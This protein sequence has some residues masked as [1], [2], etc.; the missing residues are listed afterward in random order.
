M[1]CP[2]VFFF[3]KTKSETILSTGFLFW[4]WQII[5]IT[6][7]FIWSC[8]FYC[9]DNREIV[10]C[11]NS[12]SISKMFSGNCGTTH[13]A[14]WLKCAKPLKELPHREARSKVK[15]KCLF[16]GFPI[17]WKLYSW[18]WVFFLMKLSLYFFFITKIQLSQ[19]NLM[20]CC[21]VNPAWQKLQL[22]S[23]SSKG[24]SSPLLHSIHLSEWC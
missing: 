21:P 7:W 20:G 23:S 3:K 16:S 17:F 6:R 4:R 14:V 9:C 8:K 24:V 12:V 11:F 10:L 1:H 2:F 15:S 5:N 22:N 18:F 19:C 13:R